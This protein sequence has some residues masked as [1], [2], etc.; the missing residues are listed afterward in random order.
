MSDDVPPINPTD[1]VNQM[2]RITKEIFTY[3]ASEE[4]GLQLANLTAELDYHLYEGGQLPGQWRNVRRGRPRAEED[5]EVLDTVVHGT[6]GGYNRGCHC[7][8][9]RK[10][11]REY[12]AG[13]RSTKRKATP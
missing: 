1:H 5:G 13:H 8:R 7:N 10:A 9:C 11:N 4:L 3:G 12:A 6:R 2:R